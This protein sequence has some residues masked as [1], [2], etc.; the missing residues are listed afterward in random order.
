MNGAVLAELG[1]L[2]DALVRFG[3]R[4]R[5]M[6]VLKNLDVKDGSLAESKV[7]FAAALRQGPTAIEQDRTNRQHY[8]LPPEFFGSFL[9]YRRKY[10]CC[11]WHDGVGDLDAAEEAML[12]MTASRAGIEPGQKI[13]DLGCGWG[14]FSLWAAEKFPGIKIHSLSNSSAQIEHILSEASQRG[15]SNITAERGDVTVWST[16][17]RYDRV[18]S[19]EM[20]EHIR[21]WGDLF[22]KISGWLEPEGKCFLHFFCHRDTPYLFQDQDP[23]DWMGYHFFAGGMMPSHDLPRYFQNGLHLEEYWPVN[24]RHYVRTL[25]A[26]LQKMDS[27]RDRIRPILKGAYGKDWRVWKNRWRIFLMACSELFGTDGGEEWFVSHYL[28]SKKALT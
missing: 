25:E 23:S 26:W 20:V 1:A 24:G 18:V 6:G 7:R 27:N 4:R 21:D 13:L 2:P 12:T 3:I 8:E 17:E 28:L 16:E 11:Y 14:S 15:L 10:S 9:G 5:L 19:I 22:A